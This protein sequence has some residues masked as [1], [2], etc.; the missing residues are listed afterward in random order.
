MKRCAIPTPGSR[1]HR[2]Q[3]EKYH[4]QQFMAYVDVGTSILQ[5]NEVIE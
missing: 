2:R 5:S 4:V 3:G 1:Q